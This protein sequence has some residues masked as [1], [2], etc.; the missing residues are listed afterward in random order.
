M[1]YQMNGGSI[2]LNNVIQHPSK[3]V[4]ARLAEAEAQKRGN[5]NPSMNRIQLDP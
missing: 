5:P 3:T 4:Q 2:I 1:K